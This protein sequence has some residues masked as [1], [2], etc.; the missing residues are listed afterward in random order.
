MLNTQENLLITLYIS[1]YHFITNN[2]T[3]SGQKLEKRKRTLRRGWI[4]FL[5][6]KFEEKIKHCSINAECTH[7]KKVGKEPWLLAYTICKMHEACRYRFVVYQTP[8]LKQSFNV[9]IEKQV[10]PNQ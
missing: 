9:L 8:D 3:I 7:V 2:V 6:K 4:H 5:R 10:V 1:C